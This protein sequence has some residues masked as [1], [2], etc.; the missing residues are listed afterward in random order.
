[1]AC[2]DSR[3]KDHSQRDVLEADAGPVRILRPRPDH[4]LVRAD[5]GFTYGVDRVR[6]QIEDDLLQM[7]AVTWNWP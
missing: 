6:E 7:D 3:T 1:M 2:E 5:A 4:D